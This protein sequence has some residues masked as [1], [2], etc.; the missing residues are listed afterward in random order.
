MTSFVE[1]PIQQPSS[2]AMEST[3]SESGEY[4]TFDVEQAIFFCYHFEHL[5]DFTQT[6]AAE[7]CKSDHT[8]RQWKADFLEHDEI[9]ESQ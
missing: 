5:W 6:K 2:T 4:P 7:H 1:G 9:P 3:E 8:I